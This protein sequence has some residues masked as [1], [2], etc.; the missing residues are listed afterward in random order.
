MQCCLSFRKTPEGKWLWPG[1]GDNSRVLKW[2]FDRCDNAIEA[3]TTAI[4]Y[5]PKPEDID[6][7][8]MKDTTLDDMK[9]LLDVDVDGWKKEVEGIKEHYKKF[10][11]KLPKELSAE[12]AAL[13]E[14]LNKA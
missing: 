11:D 5:M 12:L 14:R 1:Y 8:G 9:Q 3:R 6:I 10:G 13:E 7:S 4:G 2:I